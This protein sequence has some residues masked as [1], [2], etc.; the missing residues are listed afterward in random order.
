[1][2]P[3]YEDPE[4][5]DTDRGKP[6]VYPAGEQI[7]KEPAGLRSLFFNL[8]QGVR[9]GPRT[10][11]TLDGRRSL[12]CDFGSPVLSR[13]RGHQSHELIE[14]IGRIVGPRRGLGMVLDGKNRL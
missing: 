1:M 9:S 4:T 12:G 3:L 8:L 6:E 10:G 14:E 2:D 11:S 7:R 13:P 5:R